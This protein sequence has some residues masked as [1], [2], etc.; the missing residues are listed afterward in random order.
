MPGAGH[1]GQQPIVQSSTFV[2]PIGSH[3]DVLYTRYG[4]TQPDHHRQRLAA[5]EGAEAAIFSPAAW[6]PRRSRTWPAPPR[7]HLLA[8][9]WIYG[10]TRTLF[11][12]SS[13]AWGSRSPTWTLG[14]RGWAG[15]IRK[16]TARCS[17]RRPQSLARILD[18]EPIVAAC[19]RNK[20]ALLVDA[21]FASPFNFRA[22]ITRRR[23]DSQRDQY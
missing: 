18:L 17:S 16:N 7:D 10:G 23:G 13:T 11:D 8:S 6:A 20:L 14:A 5:L 4:T 12:T 9:A 19:R 1:A 2:N 21:S 22:W 15:Q 3:S